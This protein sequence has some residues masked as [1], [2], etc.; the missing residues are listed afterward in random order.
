VK[1]IKHRK[2]EEV[3]KEQAG[4]K[5]VRWRTRP[6]MNEDASTPGGIHN[7]EIVGGGIHTRVE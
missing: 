2:E 7:V 4:G 1:A 6:R 3:A 5:A